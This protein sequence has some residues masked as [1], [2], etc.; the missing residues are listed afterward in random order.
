MLCLLHALPRHHLS[1]KCS[2]CCEHV[3]P[4]GSPD[5]I[6]W[7]SCL[8]MAL[9]VCYIYK[10]LRPEPPL[11]IIVA[12]ISLVF[13]QCL[14]EENDFLHSHQVTLIIPPGLRYEAV[15]VTACLWHRKWKDSNV[16]ISNGGFNL[17]WQLSVGA[18][19]WKLLQWTPLILSLAMAAAGPESI[20]LL[21]WY[22]E[23]ICGL[24]HY[25]SQFSQSTFS[26]RRLCNDVAT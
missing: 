3:L 19:M 11:G 17:K 4:K 5:P 14:K 6:S 10:K 13:S 1:A 22:R 23:S 9:A 25:C 16:L 18:I 15:T 24:P 12:R 7:S 21:Y 2:C 26:T 20:F 8:K